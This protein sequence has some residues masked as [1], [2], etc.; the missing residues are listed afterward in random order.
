MH[1]LVV[2]DERRAA[3]NLRAGLEKNG[4]TV[5]VVYDG[6]MAETRL[7]EHSF[8]AVVLDVMI[9]KIDGIEVLHRIRGSNN[10]V[11][12][13]LLSALS[14]YDDR[15]KGLKAGADDYMTKPYGIE[16]LVIRIENLTR[17]HR[18]EIRDRIEIDDLQIN[19]QERM[20]ARRGEDLLLRPREYE[21][22][23]V[24]ARSPGRIFTQEQI[25]RK[26][27]G[28]NFDPTTNIVR[29]TITRLR[30]KVD[31]D[32]SAPL[33]ETVHGVGYRL[34]KEG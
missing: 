32:R 16:E 4:F 12:V 29:V 25:H 28:Y 21:L 33:I 2:E 3:F 9:P 18:E 34:R 30:N 31:K 6:A 11:P 15:L 13:I 22:L 14:E 5:D 7:G 8:D 27:W 23:L 17:K 10:S 1:I 19:L 24:L 20:V 26:V